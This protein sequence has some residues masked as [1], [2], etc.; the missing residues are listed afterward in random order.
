MFIKTEKRT[1]NI[2]P[3]AFFAIANNFFIF[4]PSYLVRVM[5]PANR[6]IRILV[7]EDF[8]LDQVPDLLAF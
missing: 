7:L 6:R 2:M 8:L 1:Y 5:L 4:L 3:R